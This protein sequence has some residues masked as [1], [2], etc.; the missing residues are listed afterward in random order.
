PGG[1]SAGSQAARSRLPW[2]GAKVHNM[3]NDHSRQVLPNRRFRR[4]F[5]AAVAAVT[6][7]ASAPFATPAQ[8]AERPRAPHR[9]Y[10]HVTPAGKIGALVG[11]RAS[12]DPRVQ[13]NSST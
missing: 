9:E 10:V 7:A 1:V 3:T 8:A 2:P 13:G 11:V 5:P 12:P 6:I 4:L